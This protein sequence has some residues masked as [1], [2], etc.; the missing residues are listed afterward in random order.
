M[1][2]LKITQAQAR[3]KAAPSRKAGVALPPPDSLNDAQLHGKLWQIIRGVTP[4]P[5]PHPR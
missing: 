1:D 5:T 4:P 3:R 2:N